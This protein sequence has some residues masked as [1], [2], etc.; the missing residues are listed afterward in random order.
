MP[1]TYAQC[2][3]R[4]NALT[5]PVTRAAIATL[6]LSGRVR[7]LDAGCGVGTHVGWLLD[8]IGEHG[9]V[10]GL[11]QSLDRL[12]A[13]RA[14]TTSPC[15]D[16]VEGN[17]LVLPFD[18]HSFDF[19]WC[20]D[21]L[22]PGVIEDPARVLRGFRRVV[23]PGGWIALWH[24]IDQALLCGHPQVEA[25]LRAAFS[26]A[27]PYIAGVL[28]QRQV[29]NARGWLEEAGLVP[30][31]TQAFVRTL[32]GPLKAGEQEAVHD[33]IDM[34][35]QDVVSR[36]SDQDQ[37]LYATIASRIGPHSVTRMPSY[38][39]WIVYSLHVAT[40]VPP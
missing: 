15:V 11:D 7:G 39:G 21:T 13:A 31:T 33:A 27:T 5:E 10:T 18:D 25:R 2:L 34:L 36:L 3:T 6:P 14:N 37:L 38:F 26:D 8:R 24:W 40:V 35:Y 30:T 9:H 22:W 29:A 16:W 23:R 28:P 4:M 12:G 32:H 20:A 19:V 17:L 1:M